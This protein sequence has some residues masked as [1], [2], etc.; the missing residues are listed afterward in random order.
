MPDNSVILIYTVNKSPRLIYILKYIFRTLL[1]LEFKLTD[2][3]EELNSYNGCRLNYSEEINDS[4]INIYAEGLL[5]ENSIIN[6]GVKVKDDINGI[7]C[8]FPAPEGFSM[9]FDIFSASFYLLSRYEEYLPY[10]PDSYGRFEAVRSISFRN[11]FLE[12]PIIEIWVEQLKEII[13]NEFPVTL[14]RDKKYKFIPTL[15]ID[16]PW[17]YLHKG[18]IMTSGGIIKDLFNFRF[19]KLTKRFFVLAG[20]KPDPFD[21]C[22][23]IQYLEDKSACVHTIFF[24]LGNY[25]A[26]DC[27]YAVYSEEF[28]KLIKQISR[29][30]ETGV[31]L[32]FRSN[33]NKVFM[34]R[35]INLFKDL[36]GHLPEINRQHYLMLKF[37]DTYRKLLETGI[38]Y[39]YSMGYASAPG[40]RAGTSTPF[41]FY[42]LMNEKESMLRVV[43]FQIMD[44]S[45]QKYM[46]L[47]PD[48]AIEK[49]KDIIA[50]VKKVNGTFC[51][52]WHNESLSEQ[53]QWKGWKRVYME[54]LEEGNDNLVI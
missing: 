43:P 48:E 17:A 9:K 49:I 35:E 50:V 34:T 23:Y 21:N 15:D 29:K 28:K 30:R 10:E 8:L 27:N 7:K 41:F 4:A 2:N 22:S 36:T 44:V 37:P 26:E 18:F 20:K 11:N 53:G 42:D 45:L 25:G 5:K 40:F 14:F 33:T 47:S 54:M 32:S 1:G 38:K 39:D 24:Q 46:Q 31:H 52:I 19:A 6:R 12:L 16:S 3:S 51:S 13:K